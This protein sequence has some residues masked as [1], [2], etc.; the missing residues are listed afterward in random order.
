MM[1]VGGW[2]VSV[3]SPGSALITI[4]RSEPHR[5]HRFVLGEKCLAQFAQGKAAIIIF[6]LD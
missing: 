3:N 5:G 1:M 4:P 2:P 6:A